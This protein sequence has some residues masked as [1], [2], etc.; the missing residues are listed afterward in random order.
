[1][2]CFKL[3]YFMARPQARALTATQVRA[4]GGYVPDPNHKYEY[5]HNEAR[6]TTLKMPSQ[7][8]LGYQAPKHGTLDEKLA[9][10]IAGEGHKLDLPIFESKLPFPNVREVVESEMFAPFRR[11]GQQF[12]YQWYSLK[13]EVL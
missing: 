10:W 4:F 1:M 7:G 12:L 11:V 13:D 3:H 6:Q 2:N 8:D 9:Q 5:R